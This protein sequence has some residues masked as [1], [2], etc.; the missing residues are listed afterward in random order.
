MRNII[1]VF[2]A[3]GMAR[4]AR[5]RWTTG[6]RARGSRT[7]LDDASILELMSRADDTGPDYEKRLLEIINMENWMRTWAMIDLGSFW[8]SFGN[9]N[10]KNSYIYKPRDSGWVQFVWDMDVG[11]G[12]DSRDPP[13][14]ALFP[15]KLNPTRITGLINIAI[16][17]IG[18]SKGIPKRTE[19]DHSP[20]SHPVLHINN[21]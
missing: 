3:D 21:F 15:H 7:R 20:S 9:T 8:D 11:L 16:L 5:Y 12:V 2:E 17:V 6:A 13:N 18:I 1:D 10:Y 19:V 4:A 14:Q